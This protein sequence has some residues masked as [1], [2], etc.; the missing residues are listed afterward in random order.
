MNANDGTSQGFVAWRGHKT[1]YEQRGRHGAALVLVPGGPGASSH[2][3]SP[4]AERMAGA[5]PRVVRYDPLGSGNS[6]RERPAEGWSVELFLD[7]LQALREHLSLE[8]VDLLGHSWGGQLSIEHVLRGAE[9]VRSLILYSSMASVPHYLREVRRLVDALPDEDRRAIHSHEASGT[10]D[11][12][13]YQRAAMTFM[14]RHFCRLDPWPTV[15]SRQGF[16]EDVYGTLWGPSEFTGTGPLAD[17][18]VTA[19]LAQ[20]RAPT[21]ILSGGHDFVGPA[22]QDELEGRLPDA[23]RVVLHDSAHM[24]HLEQAEEF[25]QAVLGFLRSLT[26]DG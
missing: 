11:N 15:L 7:E 10:Y 4:L 20:V 14:R 12:E 24:A 21:L 18:D 5:L 22:V 6:D 3:L 2:Y 26:A 16:G 23:R 9:G 1:W 25:D 13:E 17:W 19:R 8:D